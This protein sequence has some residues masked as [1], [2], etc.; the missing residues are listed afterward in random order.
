MENVTGSNVIFNAIN[1]SIRD[2]YQVVTQTNDAISIKFADG[3][4]GNAPKGIIR[5]WFRSTNGEEY[6]IRADDIQNQQILIP[7]FSKFDNQLY[8]L[9][10]T[11]DLEEPIK[12]SATSE[13]NTSIQTKAPFVYSTQNRMVSA[14]DLSLIHI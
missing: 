7:Y 8:D 13:S 9:S 6:T 11:F 14:Q 3:R 1:N 5:I 12:N 10:L 4:F 2:I